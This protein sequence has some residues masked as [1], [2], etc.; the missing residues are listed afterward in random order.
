VEA[1]DARV[2]ELSGF[3]HSYPVTGQTYSRK[4]D[5]D[6]IYPLSS[7]GSTAHK[8][9]T[10]IRLLANLKEVEE[11][12]EAGQIGS[13][14][15]AYK[16]NPMRCERICSLSRYLMGC[17]NQ[18]LG[19]GAIQWMERTLDD[20]YFPQ[21]HYW[22]SA[23][24]RIVIPEAFLTADTVL[25][26]LNNIF[27][28]LV[29]YPATI[30]KHI[31]AEL[32]FMATENIIM[33]MVKRGASR[34]ECHEKIRVLSVAAARVVKEEGGDNDLLERIRGDKYF[35]PIWTELESLTDERTFTG[36]AAEQVTKFVNEN[37]ATTLGDWRDRITGAKVD[38]KV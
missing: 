35:E 32:P 21:L 1:L 34:Q 26:L 3:K 24:R 6:T 17:V 5:A 36:R 37:V 14:A 12:L 25:L 10:D 20:R 7:L 23:I 18:T 27:S 30:R 9:A 19:T 31:R 38:L 33:E 29:V 4:V 16:R 11:P 13:S 28:G 15:M 8:I 22:C 2:T